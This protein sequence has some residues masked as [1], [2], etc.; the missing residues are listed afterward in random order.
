MKTIILILFV[1]FINQIAN[2]QATWSVQNPVGNSSNFKKIVFFNESTGML[3]A[4]GI[5]ISKTTN[6]GLTWNRFNTRLDSNSVS[7][8]KLSFLNEN[9]GYILNN[10]GV[11]YKTTNGGV[12]FQNLNAPVTGD[13]FRNGVNFINEN[14]GF[15]FGNQIYRT[16]NGGQNWIKLNVPNARSIYNMEYHTDIIFLTYLDSVQNK[17]KLAKSTDFGNSYSVSNII[18]VNNYS[19][20]D[21]LKCVG[22]SIYAGTISYGSRIYKSSDNGQ[23]WRHIILDFD[24]SNFNDATFFDENTGLL[25]FGR[26]EYNNAIRKTTDGGFSWFPIESE[27]P[28][29]AITGVSKIN[30]TTAYLSG[31]IGLI[32]KTENSGNTFTELSK[33]ITTQHLRS[34]SFCNAL[35]GLSTGD[36]GIVVRTSNGGL[37]WNKINLNT[38]IN[39]NNIYIFN[40]GN[41]FL[42]GD[43]SGYYKSSDFGV[44]WN[45]IDM[46]LYGKKFYSHFL[47]SSMGVIVG[48]YPLKMIYTSTGGQN[49]NHSF[50]P[51]GGGQYPGGSYSDYRYVKCVGHNKFIARR[52]YC[53]QHGPCHETLYY[54]S[55]AGANWTPVS[56]S[57]AST[58]FGMIE[59][60][61]SSLI[62][63]SKSCI[64]GNPETRI[65]KNLFNSSMQSSTPF[66]AYYLKFFNDNWGITANSVKI[67][68]N[69]GLNWI[70]LNKEISANDISMVD[71]TTAYYVGYNGVITKVSGIKLITNINNE[72]TSHITP[73]TFILKQNYPNPFNPVTRIEFT[74]SQ[75]SQPM[76][77][78]LSVYDLS[79]KLISELINKKFNSGTYIIDFNG[80]NLPSGVYFYKLETNN[81]SES[82]KMILIK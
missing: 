8:H 47:S 13:V 56:N 12:S 54:T 20:F 68:S 14:T 46:L 65:T 30:S 7:I 48:G 4:E 59:T 36:S 19:R 39:F 57:C 52:T 67:T 51:M 50:I 29:L 80:Q 76:Q 77:T 53:A 1:F 23:S 72:E 60:K 78:R 69:S 35:T 18:N 28:R 37:N 27:I 31:N 58:Q 41:A 61:D 10:S 43:T 70:S 71:S 40:D 64:N 32:L 21:M 38:K 2:S 66:G 6:G 62:Y 55:N 42:T 17:F 16:N 74:L 26:D 25:L 22:N 15:I 33:R 82:K 5:E 11:L 75:N 63:I 24:C 3:F 34:V 9:T 44:T 79:G 45:Y 49:W 81:Y 73:S